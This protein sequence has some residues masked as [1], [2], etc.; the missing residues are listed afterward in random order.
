MAAAP[1]SG[2]AGIKRALIAFQAGALSTRT[3]LLRLH[4]WALGNYPNVDIIIGHRRRGF[5]PYMDILWLT[6]RSSNG[7]LSHSVERHHS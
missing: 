4:R 2:A 3:R 6:C 5:N 7:A 1:G